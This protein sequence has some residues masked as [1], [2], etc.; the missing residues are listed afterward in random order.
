MRAS[1]N[2]LP[3]LSVGVLVGTG[4]TVLSAARPQGASQARWEYLVLKAKDDTATLNRVGR[5]GWE[6]VTVTTAILGGS[7]PG[8]PGDMFF[9]R[10]LP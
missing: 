2:L 3:F 5:D 8:V 4:I 9:K 6:L 10:P 7:A 1:K